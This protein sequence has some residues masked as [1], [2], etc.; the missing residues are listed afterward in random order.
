MISH[1]KK[2]ILILP[3][4]TGGTSVLS[5]LFEHAVVYKMFEQQSGGFDYY[6]TQFDH[7]NQIKAKH[8]PL[9]SYRSHMN[10]YKLYG[11]ARDP[12]SRMVSWWRFRAPEMN[13]KDWLSDFGRIPFQRMTYVDYFTH[14]DVQVNNIIF[15]EH[16]QQGFESMCDDIDV[17]HQLLPHKNKTNHNHYMEYYDDE[18]REIV[19]DKFQVDI[20]YYESVSA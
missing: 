17:D 8:K 1:D 19:A 14:G 18:T 15:T 5:V 13:F 3:P 20:S 7:D 12:F 9:S 11:I 6:E 10:T 4:K 16:L 2:F